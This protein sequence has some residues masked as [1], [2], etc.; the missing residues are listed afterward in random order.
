VGEHWMCCR[1]C[2]YKFIPGRSVTP[3]TSIAR[4]PCPRCGSPKVFDFNPTDDEALDT[5]VPENSGTLYDLKNP[6]E[7]MTIPKGFEAH[8][9]FDEEWRE[10]RFGE[11]TYRITKPLVLFHKS[12]GQTHRVL[13]IFGVVHCVP[14]PGRLTCILR[15]KSKDPLVPVRF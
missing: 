8:V 5:S 1:T 3:V 4:S 13:D 7:N 9:L 6:L 12:G 2:D 14:A 15:W 11:T 10:Y